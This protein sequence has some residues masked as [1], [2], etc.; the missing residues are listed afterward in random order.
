MKKTIA[1]LTTIVSLVVMTNSS[2]LHAQVF[3]KGTG[4]LNAGVGLLGYTP[5]WGVGYSASPYLNVAFD[6]GVYDFP[7][8]NKLSIGIGGYIG[9]KSISYSWTGSWEDKYERWHYN[10]PVKETWS[11]TAFGIR[12]TVHY[13]LLDNAEIYGGLSLGYVV[14]GYRTNNPDYDISYRS[15]GSY[16]GFGTYA[17][18]RYYFGK[19][20][21]LY[22]ELGYGLAYLNIGVSFKF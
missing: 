13:S 20:F 2:T 15:Y 1:I 3:K 18:F 7:E 8:N 21:G 16:V 4:A 5:Y 17:G 11:Y 14:L 9:Y 10:E 22:T 6:Y 12:P 19:S